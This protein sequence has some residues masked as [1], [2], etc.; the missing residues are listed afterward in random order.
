MGATSSSS[1]RVTIERANQDIGVI[2]ITPSALGQLTTRNEEEKGQEIERQNSYPA[3]D[4]ELSSDYDRQNEGNKAGEEQ[5][6][7]PSNVDWRLLQVR[8]TGH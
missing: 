5:T 6:Q 2:K 7:G 4:H 1:R 8:A 3:A